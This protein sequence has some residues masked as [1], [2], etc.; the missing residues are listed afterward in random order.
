MEISESQKI[1]DKALD[2]AKDL[3]SKGKA[4]ESKIICQ[5]IIKCGTE[6]PHARQLLGLIEFRAGR[7]RE[8]ISIFK[9]LLIENP[10]NPQNHNNIALVYASISDYKSSIAHLEKAIEID[11]TDGRFYA[12]LGLQYRN[13]RDYKNSIYN[14]TKAVEICPTKDNWNH[15][16][17]AYGENKESDK[18]KHAFYQA[19]EI[20]P[21][22]AMAHVD[23]AYCLQ[24]TG[25]WEEAW[26]HYEYRFNYFNQLQ[27][28]KT[29]YDQNK[30]WNREDLKDKRILLFCEQGLGDAIM[31]ARYIKHLKNMGAYVI[32]HCYDTIQDIMKYID[33]V[34][35]ITIAE[36]H[37]NP[38]QPLPEYDYQTSVMSLPLLL[39]KPN[40]YYEP[41]LNYTKSAN[42]EK[43]KDTFNIGIIWAGS[44][45]HPE[46]PQRSCY[47]KEFKPIYDL[48]NVKLFN[49]QKHCG[50]R[51]YMHLEE[52]VDFTE[53]AEN[54]NIINAS[55]FIN[56]FEDVA[57][58]INGLDLLVSVDTAPV[59]L[60][61]AMNKPVMM[62][63]AYNSDP[64]W[65]LYK[66]TTDW[67]P[68]IR[69]FR[70]KERNNWKEVFERIADEIKYLLQN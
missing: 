35:E 40:P 42:L 52:P 55:E 59:H 58:F 63:V 33:G 6:D 51:K 27:F 50:P 45:L 61:G 29:V 69:I 15:L 62:A 43:Y 38:P 68:T 12:N 16:G 37:T 44:P 5:Q 47:L 13:I 70:Q 34:D 10:N 24:S 8:A 46:D 17:S 28:Y 23:L 20:D 66:E 56:D 7:H 2:T 53:G 36:V 21:E 67:Y 22:F 39:N 49:L 54:M 64:R 9:Q 65:E 19:L 1:I 4:L 31:F 11:P 26:K 18:A 30:K 60:A 48:D 3:L 57:M 25:D 41:Y 32:L 14:F